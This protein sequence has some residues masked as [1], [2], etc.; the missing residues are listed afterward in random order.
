MFSGP[1][2]LVGLGLILLLCFVAGLWSRPF[3]EELFQSG[4]R[5]PSA[6]AATKIGEGLQVEVSTPAPQARQSEKEIE[7]SS[8]RRKIIPP[9]EVPPAAPPEPEIPVAPLR[10]I[11]LIL[12]DFGYNLGPEVLR[13]LKTDPGINVA[14]LPNLR[15]SRQTM[16]IARRWNHEILIHAPFEGSSYATEEEFIRK[17]DP[18]ERI[19]GLLEKWHRSLPSAVGINNHQ[20][21]VATVHEPTMRVVMR[22]L[23]EN[24]MLF[25][26]S[27]TG[28]SPVSL[29][30][31]RA[32]GVPS[33][34]R[35]VPFLDNE[36]TEEEVRRNFQLL[37]EKASTRTIPIG[38]AH[39]TK[40][41]T[42]RVLLDVVPKLKS[43]G[44]QL[45]PV[46]QAVR[47]AWKAPDG[48]YAHERE[49][50]PG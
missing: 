47:P 15:Y 18:P 22:F 20:G 11:C 16:E 26:D 33:G 13:V 14:I 21:S 3:L 40:A 28:H 44:Y 31:A 49:G 5:A 48:F 34:A 19:W 45:A 9:V 29:D 25:V 4:S 12:D 1:W 42:R 50:V 38:I 30:T 17:G 7:L 41:N 46:S 39:I 32:M 8:I 23:K 24:R 6:G 37:L 35:I 2:L 27:W 10:R 43:M 36:G